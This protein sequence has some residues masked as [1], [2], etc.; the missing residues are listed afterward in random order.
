MRANAAPSTSLKEYIVFLNSPPRDSTSFWNATCRNKIKCFIRN[1]T[2]AEEG[3]NAK[4]E[5]QLDG[6]AVHVVIY[7]L[8]CCYCY[9]Y[10]SDRNLLQ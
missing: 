4:I 5:S 1:V 2:N 6:K 8:H 7:L 3:N 10:N 9:C